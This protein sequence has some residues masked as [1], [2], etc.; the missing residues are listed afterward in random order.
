VL[1][2]VRAGPFHIRGVSVGGIYTSLHVQELDVLLDVGL[3]ARSAAAVSSLFL[4]HGHAD[5]CGA[6]TTLLG[7]RM[8]TA[9]N[10]RLRL[11][12]PA[13][14]AGDIGDVLAVVSRLQRHEVNVELIP[15][16]H[17]DEVALGGDLHV[18]A[19]RTFHPVPSLGY[20]FV[21]RVLKLKR[22]H[23]GMPGDEIKRRRAAGEAL[24]EQ[25]EHAELAYATDTL[26][27]VLDTEPRLFA[28]KTLILECTFLDQRKSVADAHASCHVHLDDLLPHADR[29]ANEAIVLMH[30]SQIYRP[31]EVV[32]VL[33]E[34]CPPSLRE[35]IVP[36]V[37][38]RPHWPG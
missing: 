5:H 22:E 30:F 9:G 12:L 35:R 25:V 18:R 29:F 4:S 20:L 34:R 16:E 23:A 17:G 13:A 32:E 27:R 3:A 7:A 24:F 26:A 8:L 11:Y 6:L 36:F 38:D 14:I 19:F 37:P 21:R 2:R 15:M 33:D 1:T 31:T 28:A 10:R